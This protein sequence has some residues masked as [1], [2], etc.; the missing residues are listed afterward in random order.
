MCNQTDDAVKMHKHDCQ[1]DCVLLKQPCQSKNIWSV[2]TWVRKSKYL[3]LKP[4]CKRD[5]ITLPRKTAVGEISDAN[6]I[7]PLLVMKP[8]ENDIIEVESNVKQIK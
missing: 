2:K 7:L 6:A 3:P 4:K 5:Y 8:E 1:T